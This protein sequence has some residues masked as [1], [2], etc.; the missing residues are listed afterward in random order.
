MNVLESD[1]NSTQP[2]EVGYWVS[3]WIEPSPTNEEDVRHMWPIIKKFK[4]NFP[5]TIIFSDIVC[6]C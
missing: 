5:L 1:Y 3:I 2:R 4:L 6:I